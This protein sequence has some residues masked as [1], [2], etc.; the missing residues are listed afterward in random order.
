MGKDIFLGGLLS[1]SEE[2]RWGSGPGRRVPPF[3]AEGGLGLGRG[4]ERLGSRWAPRVGGGGSSPV[5]LRA[6]RLGLCRGPT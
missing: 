3:P 4:E 5:P 1:G 2:Q 6:S